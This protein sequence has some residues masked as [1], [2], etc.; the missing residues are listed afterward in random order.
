MAGRKKG[1][2]PK[3]Y[4]RKNNEVKQPRTT[5]GNC[6]VKDKYCTFQVGELADGLCYYHFDHRGKTLGKKGTQPRGTNV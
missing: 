2:K 5:W 3:E 1:S 6:M 4:P